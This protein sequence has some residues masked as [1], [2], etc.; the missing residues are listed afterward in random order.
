MLAVAA[1]GE[2]AAS[3]RVRHRPNRDDGLLLKRLPFLYL[4][5]GDALHLLLH[6]GEQME[7]GEVGAFRL[8]FFIVR[9]CGNGGLSARRLFLS[10]I[11]LYTISFSAISSACCVKLFTACT[12]PI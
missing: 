11:Y 9:R 4:G 3:H 12:Q 6:R 2:G 5:L 10:L 8:R 7:L 1:A